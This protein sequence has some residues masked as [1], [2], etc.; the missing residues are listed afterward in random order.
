MRQLKAEEALR[1]DPAVLEEGGKEAAVSPFVPASPVVESM[2]VSPIVKPTSSKSTT[3][4]KSTS[5]FKSAVSSVSRKMSAKEKPA[6]SK[7]STKTVTITEHYSGRPPTERKHSVFDRVSRMPW[8]DEVM[9]TSP[10]DANR[11]SLS[12]TAAFSRRKTRYETLHDLATRNSK[13]P[14]SSF[15]SLPSHLAG[16]R[17]PLYAMDDLLPPL[18]S[19][20]LTRSLLIDDG[21]LD[22]YMESPARGFD[23]AYRSEHQ[24]PSP[25]SAITKSSSL[26]GLAPSPQLI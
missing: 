6:S 21:A 3:S 26:V 23:L 11:T 2:A 22:K 13:L 18:G 25:R 7:D 12:V 8:M 5:S 10:T 19:R 1:Q 24:S 15:A 17:S 16:G 4:L 9:A 14:A 20:R